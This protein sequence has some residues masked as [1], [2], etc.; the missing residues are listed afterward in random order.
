MHYL[1]F[2]VHLKRK[3]IKACQSIPERQVMHADNDDITLVK[4][5][6]GTNLLAN[7]HINIQL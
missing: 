5:I 2:I 7:N 3:L 1:A 6:F 4:P